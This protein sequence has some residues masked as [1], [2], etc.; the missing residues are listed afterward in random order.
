MALPKTTDP[1]LPSIGGLGYVGEADSQNYITVANGVYFKNASNL[2]TP[3]SAT[4]P[5]PAELKSSIETVNTVSVVGV[6]TVTAT[7]AEIFAGASAKANRRKLILKNED[8][9]LRFRVGPSNVTQQNGF[10]VEPGAVVEFQFDPSTAIA[11][12][13]ISE[14]ANIQVAVMEI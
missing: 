13:A 2:W 1:S 11:I 12:Y 14:G 4:A 10:P 9:V 7:A 3:V 8:P 6:K 5:I